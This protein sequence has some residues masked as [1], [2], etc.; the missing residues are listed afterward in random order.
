MRPEHRAR[1]VATMVCQGK[2]SEAQANKLIDK[3]CIGKRLRTA[4]DEELLA[5]NGI[6][7]ATVD[8]VRAWVGS[9]K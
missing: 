4:T 7:Q 2:L 8:K 1:W 6:G 9:S 3:G 5:M